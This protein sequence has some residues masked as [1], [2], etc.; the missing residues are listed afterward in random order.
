M[1]LLNEAFA[2][3]TEHAGAR[4]ASDL[5]HALCESGVCV[6]FVTHLFEFADQMAAEEREDALFLRAERLSNGNRSFRM[7]PGMPLDTS[8]GEDLFGKWLLA[9]SAAFR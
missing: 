6:L 1:I 9:G 5:V 7:E 2:T 3:T 8:Y 4:I